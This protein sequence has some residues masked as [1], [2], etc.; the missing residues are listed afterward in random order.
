M[1][2][3]DQHT[4]D[5]HR[6]STDQSPPKAEAQQDLTEDLDDPALKA[7][8]DTGVEVRTPEPTDERQGEAGN[9]YMGREMNDAMKVN[10]RIEDADRVT[11]EDDED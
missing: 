4:P 2:H 3:P 10:P 11:D 1:G 9:A 5:D 8:A 7:D 6:S